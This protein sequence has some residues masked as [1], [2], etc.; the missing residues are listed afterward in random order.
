MLKFKNLQKLK[1]IKQMSETNLVNIVCDAQ[2]SQVG[3]VVITRTSHLCDLG[4]TPGLCTWTEI[5][6]I[7]GLLLGFFSGY[8]GF[9]PS[10]MLC[11][12]A[13]H[14]LYSSSQRHLCMLSV[15]PH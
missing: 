2:Q 13:M 5:C 4:S 1:N 11:S 10:L 9:P 7:S 14:G 3:I 15:R 6:N 12:E 8:S